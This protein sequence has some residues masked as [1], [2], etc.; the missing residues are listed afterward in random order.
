LEPDE[1]YWIKNEK[2]MRDKTKWDAK[3][4][5]PPDLA[6]DVTHSSLNRMGIY[7][8][9][10]IPE[11]WRHK[12][13]KLR[14]YVLGE[15]GRYHEAQFSSIFPYLDM[16]RVNE[17]LQSAATVDETTLL[18]KFAAWVRREVLP[19]VEGQPPRNGS[20]PGKK[21]VTWGQGTDSGD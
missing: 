5:P 14:V 15:D 13:K 20:K 2:A 11:V 16:A 18:R 17:F 12:G 3:K 7:A 4:D 9:L 1:C 21:H 10:C 19:L 6:V 8:A